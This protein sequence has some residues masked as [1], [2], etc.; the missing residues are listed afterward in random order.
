MPTAT[1][2]PDTRTLVRDR[3]AVYGAILNAGDEIERN[4]RPLK[5]TIREA[6]K[7]LRFES[8]GTGALLFTG[9]LAATAVDRFVTSFWFW[10]AI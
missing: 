9:P 2:S 10:T 3:L 1:L 6:G 7:R 5:V 8:A 4:N